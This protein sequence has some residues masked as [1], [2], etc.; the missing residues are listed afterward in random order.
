MKITN[1]Y[2]QHA[3]YIDPFLYPGK[4]KIQKM[5]KGLGVVVVGLVVVGAAAVEGPVE[6]GEVG[7]GQTVPVVCDW[8]QALAVETRE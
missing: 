6:G 4:Q 3:I 7:A 2:C 8:I 1:N 5:Q